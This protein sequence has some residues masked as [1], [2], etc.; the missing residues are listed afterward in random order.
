MQYPNRSR[1]AWALAAALG[2][3]GP[4]HAF[5]WDGWPGSST[6]VPR[7]LVPVADGP[8]SPPNPTAN[9]TFPPGGHPTTPT[10]PT[11]PTSPGGPTDGPPAGPPITPPP[12]NVPEPATG[13]A[14]LVGLGVLATRRLRRVSPAGR[15]G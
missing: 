13:L 15:A 9:P 1:I 10:T 3:A 6:P 7:S 5:Y 4:A 2:S 11:T 8:K 14:M 12:E